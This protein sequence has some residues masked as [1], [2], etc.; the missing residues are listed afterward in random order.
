MKQKK[1]LFIAGVIAIVS[2]T[3]ISFPSYGASVRGV[4]DTTI[5]VGG[6]WDFTG[7]VATL[8]T[9]V[10]SGTRT[11]IRHINDQGGIHGRKIKY[12]LEDDRYTIPA[13]VAAFKKLVHRDEIFALLGPGST[14]E[15]K[16]LMSQM[17]KQRLPTLPCAADIDLIDPPRRYIFPTIDTYDHM[18]G[19]VFGWIVQESKPKKPKLVAII[20]DVAAK[21][22]YVRAMEKWAKFFDLN[23]SIVMTTVGSVDLTGEILRTRR[24]KPDYVIPFMTLPATA[25]FM[26][27]AWRFYKFKPRLYTTYSSTSEDV[28]RLAGEAADHFYGVHFYSSWYDDNPGM[29]ELRKITLNYFPGTE[30]PY[31]PK[32]YT[33]GW[34][35][36]KLLHEGIQRAGRDLD[37][38][39]FVDALEGLRDFETG[40][41]SGPITLTSKSHAVVKYCRIYKGDPAT[42]KLIPISDWR[43]APKIK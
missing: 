25:A 42:G 41:I 30:K 43:D 2:I 35:T 28:V 4:T 20:T 1:S 29:A 37:N 21:F 13:A 5:K 33:I 17:M 15:T 36:A 32:N 26:R 31:R 6:I 22:Q 23:V 3:L 19:V 38:E 34:M 27:D 24:E 9:A 40:G 39:K 7:P 12:I 14:G 10:A 16:V 18:L 11:Y 8:W